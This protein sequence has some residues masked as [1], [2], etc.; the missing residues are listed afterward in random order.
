AD[1]GWKDACIQNHE[2][3]LGLNFLDGHIVYEAVAEPFGLPYTDP[4][5]LLA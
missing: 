4:K 5:T 3:W 1:K 2:L